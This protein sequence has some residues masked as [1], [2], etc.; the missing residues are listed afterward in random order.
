MGDLGKPTALNTSFNQ[1]INDIDIRWSS[2][3]QLLINELG[4]GQ[5]EAT[6]KDFIDPLPVL[7]ALEKFEDNPVVTIPPETVSSSFWVKR[8]QA[9]ASLSAYSQ[10]PKLLSEEREQIKTRVSELKIFLEDLGFT[11]D[12]LRKEIRDCMNEL[13]EFAELERKNLK[14]P[15]NE[16]N[17]LYTSNR[18]KEDKE[19]WA[20]SLAKSTTVIE[21]ERDIDTLCFDPTSLD[22]AHNSLIIITKNYLNC[23]ER[24][25][26]AQEINNVGENGKTKEDLLDELQLFSDCLNEN[27]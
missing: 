22:K 18:L 17:I 2:T 20:N 24:E 15:H 8:F 4:V 3:K 1:L 10:L 11:G 13:V 16:F 12:D 7:K 9:V 26:T 25:L 19:L 23:V 5:G 27:N 14:Y 6:P 21:N